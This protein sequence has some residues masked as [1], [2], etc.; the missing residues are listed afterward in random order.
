MIQLPWNRNMPSRHLTHTEAQ[1][2]RI[3]TDLGVLQGVHPQTQL[4]KSMFAHVTWKERNN[5]TFFSR[6]KDRG[7]IMFLK[8][9]DL[10]MNPLSEP[11]Q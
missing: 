11:V 1:K 9:L 2:G 10:R 8:Y 7:M 3:H 6:G 5:T 4:A